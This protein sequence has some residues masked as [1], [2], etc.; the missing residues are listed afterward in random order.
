M[1]N[2]RLDSIHTLVEPIPDNHATM[3]AKLDHLLTATKGNEAHIRTSSTLQ[4]ASVDTITRMVRAELRRVVIPSVEEYHN[5]YHSSHNMQLDG[6]R[7]DLDQIVSALGHL[8][9]GELAAKQN[10]GNQESATGL[11]DLDLR[12]DGLHHQKIPTET[13][14][15][16]SEVVRR[17][18]SN[19]NYIVQPWSHSW[20][21]TWIFNWRIGVL[22]VHIIASH[23]RPS[24]RQ[25]EFQAFE[26]CRAPLTRHSYLVSID[27][28]PA[29][30]LLVTRGISIQCKSQQDQR[31]SYEICPRLVTF[32]IVPDDAEVFKC[33]LNRDLAGLKVLFEK[34]LAAPTDRDDD[35][36]SLVHVS[37]IPV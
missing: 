30:S 9:V 2:T 37:D 24:V 23:R 32:A 25:Q 36:W 15:R 28:Q 14:D 4:A 13:M 26:H 10:K 18:N 11:Q 33:V 29:P 17:E 35:L 8:S 16:S 1:Q 22:I 6:I 21:R 31:G 7:R 20:G 3:M 27:F 19:D 12:D 34:G 5:P